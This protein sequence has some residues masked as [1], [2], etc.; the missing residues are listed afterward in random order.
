VQLRFVSRDLAALDEIDVEVLVASVFSDVRPARGVAALCDWRL[1][2]R[3]SRLMREDFVTG[4]LGEVV[5]VPGKPKLAFDKVILFGLGRKATFDKAAYT[6]V[7]ERIF[8]TLSKLRVRTAVVELPGRADGMIDPTL[9]ATVVLDQSERDA[10]I[11]AW[12]LV[13]DTEARAAIEQH[14]AERRRRRR[15]LG[16]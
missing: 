2:G 12:T 6:S 3:L 1:G 4:A 13:E 8:T 15:V 10:D 5:M 7:V 11:D 16:E 14:A 9:A